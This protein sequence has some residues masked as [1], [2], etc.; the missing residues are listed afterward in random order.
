VTK[1][2]ENGL[3]I[4]ISA[5]DNIGKG[6]SSQAIQNMNIICNF[7]ETLGLEIFSQWI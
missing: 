6:A 1:D 7:L 5:I 4:I 2:K 3:G